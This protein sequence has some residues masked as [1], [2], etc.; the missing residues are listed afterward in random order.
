AEWRQTGADWAITAT[1][2]AHILWHYGKPITPRLNS[3][4]LLAEN[5][6]PQRES[7]AVQLFTNRAALGVTNTR[8]T[9]PIDPAEALDIDTHADLAAARQALGRKAILFHVVASDEKGSG[10]LRRC[11]QLSDALAHHD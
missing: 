8:V 9:I 11:L 3:Q 7:G 5:L 4:Q 2:E 1:P 10:H 6:G